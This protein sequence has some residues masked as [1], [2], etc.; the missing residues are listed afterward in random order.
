MSAQLPLQLAQ[1]PSHGGQPLPRSVRSNMERFFGTSFAD[2]R[3]HVGR[4]AAAIG[5]LAFTHGSNIHFAPGQYDPATARGRQMLA[6]ELAHVVQQRSGRVR[7]PFGSGVAVVHDARL[8]GEA[9]RMAARAG[10]MPIQR[11]IL[12]DKQ[13]EVTLLRINAETNV[14]TLESWKK[15]AEW[16]DDDLVKAID[17]RIAVVI[18]QAEEAQEKKDVGSPDNFDYTISTQLKAA[19]LSKRERKGFF[20]VAKKH[21]GKTLSQ[22]IAAIDESKN[23][24]DKSA[25]LRSFSYDLSIDVAKAISADYSK[26]MALTKDT[27]SVTRT[28]VDAIKA[29]TVVASKKTYRSEEKNQ[30]QLGNGSVFTFYIA[31]CEDQ[32][33]LEWHVHWGPQDAPQAAGYKNKGNSGEKVETKQQDHSLLKQVLTFGT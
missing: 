28:L 7:N 4:Q 22:L 31:G 2:V 20:A 33:G 24:T 25:C 11:T 18:Q 1:I 29:G 5:A 32:L 23:A 21:N 27:A 19:G 9:D 14:S 12:D 16:D 26:L 30:K 10:M 17:A 13:V 15:A 3:V 8:E 6:H